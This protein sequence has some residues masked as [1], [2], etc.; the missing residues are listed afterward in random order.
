MPKNGIGMGKTTIRLRPMSR[1]HSTHA[2]KAKTHCAGTMRQPAALRQTH[3]KTCPMPTS[4]VGMWNTAT[5]TMTAQRYGR[6]A[7]SSSA[8]ASGSRKS[9]SSSR[10]I[11]VSPTSSAKPWAATGKTGRRHKVPFQRHRRQASLPTRANISSC[12]R[13]AGFTKESS[14]KSVFS[15]GIGRQP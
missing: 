1:T 6:S 8:A 11:P 5:R 7:A 14:T 2:A 3:A 4:S 9:L 12:R 10:R 13:W 15:A